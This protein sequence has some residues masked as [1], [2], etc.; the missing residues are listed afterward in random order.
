MLECRINRG[1]LTWSASQQQDKQTLSGVAPPRFAANSLF[2]PDKVKH[3]PR[4]K[5]LTLPGVHRHGNSLKLGVRLGNLP[6][7]GLSK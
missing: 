7:E 2:R 3:R 1:H 5:L 4:Q 6:L